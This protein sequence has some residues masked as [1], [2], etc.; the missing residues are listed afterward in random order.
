MDN[1]IVVTEIQLGALIESSIRKVLADTLS[2]SNSAQN[3]LLT[4]SEACEFL[5]LAK[6]T[7]YGLTSKNEIPHIKKGKNL[8]FRRSDLN[9]WLK[10][11]DRNVKIE[12][13]PDKMKYLALTKTPA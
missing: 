9:N 8:R 5:H 12:V 7:V 1:I 3:E 6:Q 11:G 4:L 10:E 2:G 13:Q